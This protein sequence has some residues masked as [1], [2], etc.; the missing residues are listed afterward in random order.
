MTE[1]P[2]NRCYTTEQ[3]KEQK[4]LINPNKYVQ[5]EQRELG[6]DNAREKEAT[7]RMNTFEAF[8]MHARMEADE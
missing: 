3:D 1:R 5:E 4:A 8:I 6:N 7:D 2:T